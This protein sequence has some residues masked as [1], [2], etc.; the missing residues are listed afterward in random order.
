MWISY[1]LGKGLWLFITLVLEWANMKRICLIVP[2]LFLSACTLQ[3]SITPEDDVLQ[4]AIVGV[5]Y[6]G[7]IKIT[8]GKVSVLDY[9]AM[10]ERFVGTISPTNSGL[11]IQR[12][13]GDN[14]NNNCV[15]IRGNPTKPGIVKIRVAGGLFGT[16]IATGGEFDKTYTITILKAANI[17]D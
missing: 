1:K 5:N 12:C 3:A 2:I 8:G 15:Q 10:S 13:N 9:D 14:S 7:E 17:S 6:Y 11:Y 4:D 16:N